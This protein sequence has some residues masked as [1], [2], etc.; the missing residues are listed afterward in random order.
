MK[1]C[2][3]CFVEKIIIEE[4]SPGFLNSSG[5][6]FKMHDGNAEE[7]IICLS[8]ESGEIELRVFGKSYTFELPLV[9]GT[10]V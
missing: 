5:Y 4:V 10:T 3:P 2:F 6:Q 1:M 9:K 8:V 7:K